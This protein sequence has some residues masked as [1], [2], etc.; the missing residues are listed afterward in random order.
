MAVMPQ[1]TIGQNQ[2]RLAALSHRLQ[3]GRLAHARLIA[4][5]EQVC[6]RY[7]LPGF[8]CWRSPVALF[9]FVRTDGVL[10]MVPLAAVAGGAGLDN[11]SSNLLVCAQRP[12]D[13]AVCITVSGELDLG[14]VNTFRAHLDMAAHHG[15][16]IVLDVQDLRYLDSS[17]INALLNT[18]RALSLLG[19]RMAI[20]GPS[21]MIR[22]ILGVVNIEELIPVFA[23]VEA[24]LGY[25]RAHRKSDASVGDA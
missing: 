5:Y 25:V 11:N 14:T 15:G 9:R 21:K 24:A 18:Q 10:R 4:D 12:L 7:R 2:E 13:G 6:Q 1:R 19:Q 16:G 17:G 22:R 23:S 8:V 3:L 20:V